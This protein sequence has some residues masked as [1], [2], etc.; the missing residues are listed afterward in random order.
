MAVI[1]QA[2]LITGLPFMKINGESAL[3]FDIQNLKLYFFG[4]VI[5]IKEFYLI[6]IATIFLLV[7]IAFITTIFGRIWCGWLCPQTALL[8]ISEDLA[9]LLRLKS[10]PAARKILLIPVTALVSLTLIWYFVPPEE[11]INSLFR[12]KIITGFF[13]ALWF[14]IYAELVLLGRKFCKTICPYS[15]MQSGLFDSE[16]LVISFDA[17][18]KE[19]CMGCDRCVKVCPVGID[20]KKGL[21]RECIACAQCIDACSLMTKRRDIPSLIG[22]RGRILRPKTFILG[23]LSAI[24]GLLLLVM[25]HTRPEIDFVITRDPAQPAVGIN[26][27]TYSI[28]NN[29]NREVTLVLTTEEPFIFIGESVITIGPYSTIHRKVMVRVEEDTSTVT[30]ILKGAGQKLIREVGFL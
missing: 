1:A 11:T 26:R 7:L 12:S 5:W 2:A 28:Q 10:K 29:T 30:F 14:T 23:G 27:Y 18:R 3:R 8:D 22:Y 21:R 17:S 24:A 9:S 19:E 4:T 15:M 6:L 16:T 25:I 20:I 13:L